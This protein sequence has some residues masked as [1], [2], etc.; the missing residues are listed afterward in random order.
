MNKNIFKKTIISTVCLILVLSLSGCSFSFFGL[1]FGKRP[2]EPAVSNE[3]ET[4]NVPGSSDSGLPEYYHYDSSDFLTDVA[5]MLR[6]YEEGKTEDAFSLYTELEEEL[7]NVDELQG[8]SYVLYSENVNDEYYS[9]EN[10]YAT[11]T[12]VTLSDT[13]FSA[14]HEM[15]TGSHQDDFKSFL[16]DEK[17]IT[18]YQKYE[19][20]DQEQIDLFAKEND[21]V[22]KMKYDISVKGY[23]E[24]AAMLET[25]KPCN[26]ILQV[27]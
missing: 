15:I 8:I 18:E 9:N 23:R 1:H 16:G 5:E 3:P 4:A 27:N 22:L 10:D 7:L 24:Q 2:D 12:L 6:L 14:C 21:L 26:Y 13:F 19:P 17:Y 20:M 11:E 25:L